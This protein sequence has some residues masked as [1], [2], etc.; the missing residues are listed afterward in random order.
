MTPDGR[1]VAVGSGAYAAAERPSVE[2]R[3]PMVDAAVAD[4][5]SL[6]AAV[7]ALVS[8][9]CGR[10]RIFKPD[11]MVAVSSTLRGDDRR[12]VLDACVRAGARSMDLIEAP[13]A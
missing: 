6:D 9:A 2:L 11:V 7:Q 4:R 10:Q 1:V 12:Q 8:R 5:R 3:H 13:L